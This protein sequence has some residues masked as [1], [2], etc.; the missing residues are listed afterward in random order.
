MSETEF[1]AGA[2][3]KPT[4]IR[5]RMVRT[6]RYKYVVYSEGA[7]REQLFDLGADAGETHN[8]VAEPAARDILR[9]HRQW[10]AQW[11]QRTR[12]DFPAAE[13]P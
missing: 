13:T 5:G 8:L 6:A 2:G 4:G 12:D 9:G 7:H 10:L 1:A 3:R 11:A